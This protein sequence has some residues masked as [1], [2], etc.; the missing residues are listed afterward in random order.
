MPADRPTLLRTLVDRFL[1][2]MPPTPFGRLV[3]T[4]LVTMCA[5][6]CV[7]V[8][9]A[10]S[11]FFAKPSSGARGSGLLYLLV[12][13]APFAGAAPLIGPAVDRLRGL[14]RPLVTR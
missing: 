13:M 10:G 3:R 9:L 4:H 8:S 2:L 11:I 1:A 5:D 12:T 6:A 7:A 14:P